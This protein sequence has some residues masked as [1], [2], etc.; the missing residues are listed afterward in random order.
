[1]SKE[2]MEGLKF[3]LARLGITL[4]FS[5]VQK[6]ERRKNRR[7]YDWTYYRGFIGGPSLVK[8]YERVGFI[9]DRKH[10]RLKAT[11]EKAVG[12]NTEVQVTATR[13]I[14]EGVLKCGT[15]C[16]W[17]CGGW[18]YKEAEMLTMESARASI[19]KW[20]SAIKQVPKMWNAD[21]TH[22]AFRKFDKENSLECIRGVEKELDKQRTF[23][24]VVDVAE[25]DYNGMVYDL[26]VEDTHNYTVA[27]LITHNTV[28]SLHASEVSRWPSGEVYTG[29]IEP[30]MNAPDTI[31]FMESTAFGNEGFYYN[32]WEEAMDGDS[33]WTPVFLA[34]YR[35]KKYSLPLKPSQVPFK[36][37]KAEQAFTEKTK[38]EEKFQISN[39]FW[40]WR[41]RRIKSSIARTG[42]PYAHYESYPITPQEAFQSSGQGAF[43]RHKLDEQQQA[44]VCNPIWV[45]EIG[46]QGMNAAPKLF[47]NHMLDEN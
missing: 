7:H 43:P 11:A 33:D 12:T 36:L 2:L 46:Y 42:F 27:G 24:R 28:R 10:G 26:E 15:T 21:K 16:K 39:E 25:K 14:R 17:V 22:Y 37:D 18:K 20:K 41:R 32:M 30:S 47:L 45:G 38:R 3:L 9:S 35:A 23:D 13:M 29:D 34:A 4:R 31:A 40:N 5:T 8:F 19:E 44:N 1:M 6:K